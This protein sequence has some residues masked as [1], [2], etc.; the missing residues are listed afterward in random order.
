MRDY[1][2]TLSTPRLILRTP[3]REDRLKFQKFEIENSLH[4]ARWGSH[5][6]AFE[7]VELFEEWKQEFETGRSVRFL[8]IL[9]ETQGIIGIC[10]FTQIFRKSFQAC[11]LGYKIDKDYE[12]KGLMAEGLRKGIQYIFEVEKLHRIMANYMPAN[13]RSAALLQRLGFHIEGL[14]KDYLLI[15][16]QWKDH[17]LTAL[18]NPQWS[19]PS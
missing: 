6:G 5:K 15:N 10:N 7:S 16:G 8:L 11:Y 19:L 12:G 2:I 1:H 13:E 9:R 14:A 3:Q 4:F 17:I 18:T